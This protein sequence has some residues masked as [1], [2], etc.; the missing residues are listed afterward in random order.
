MTDERIKYNKEGKPTKQS[1]EWAWENDRDLF[2]D[3]QSKHFTTRGTMKDSSIMK[4]IKKKLG[5]ENKE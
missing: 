2:M 5:K 1:M 4:W 3:L